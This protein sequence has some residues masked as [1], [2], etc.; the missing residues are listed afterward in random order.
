M[1]RSWRWCAAALLLALL[2]PLGAC[3]DRG[4]TSDPSGDDESG[5]KSDEEGEGDEEEGCPKRTVLDEAEAMDGYLSA[6]KFFLK[7]IVPK[8]KLDHKDAPEKGPLLD[9]VMDELHVVLNGKKNEDGGDPVRATVD[10]SGKLKDLRLRCQAR[11]DGV[12][13]EPDFSWNRATF[14]WLRCE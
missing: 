13:G 8:V 2:L 5:E 6:R 10:F 3:P 14:K 7:Q 12:M 1:S 9:V 4:A 11:F